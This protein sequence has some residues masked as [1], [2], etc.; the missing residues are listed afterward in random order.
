VVDDSNNQFVLVLSGLVV[1]WL[2]RI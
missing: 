1:T 2:L